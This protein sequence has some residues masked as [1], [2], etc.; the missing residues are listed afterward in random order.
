MVEIKYYL[1]TY[2]LTR[3][4]WITVPS[5]NPV[6]NEAALTTVILVIAKTNFVIV[7]YSIYF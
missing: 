4:R 2:L 5:E 7:I 1:L 6:L 3:F